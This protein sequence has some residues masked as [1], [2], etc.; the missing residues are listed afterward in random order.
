ML[1]GKKRKINFN[2]KVVDEGRDIREGF[3]EYVS[4]KSKF[5]E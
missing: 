2:Y 5:K 3:L 4:F 1:C